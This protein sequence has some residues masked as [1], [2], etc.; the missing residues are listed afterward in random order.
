MSNLVFD[1]VASALKNEKNPTMRRTAGDAMSDLGNKLAVPYAA[2]A[3][4]VDRSKLVQWRAARILGELADSLEIVAV[5]KQ[6]SF[7]KDKYAFEVSFEIKDALRKVKAR[8]TQQ[9][10]LSGTPVPKTG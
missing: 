6:A 4:E 7:S 5:L 8:A 9:D 3:L 10:N 1:A 2:S